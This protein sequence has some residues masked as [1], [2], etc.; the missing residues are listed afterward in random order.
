MG[1]IAVYDGSSAARCTGG[2][3]AI[4]MLIGPNAALSIDRHLR[5]IH[6]INAYDFYKP[7][8]NSEY[9]TFDGPLSVHTYTSAVDR[10]YRLYKHK[11]KLMLGMSLC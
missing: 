10:C 5:A 4:A 11:Y 7:H 8:M 1:D 6:M 2:A 3:G 9:A